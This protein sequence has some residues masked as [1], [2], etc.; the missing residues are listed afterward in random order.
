[1]QSFFRH[2]DVV[3]TSSWFFFCSV[4]FVRSSVRPSI[5]LRPHIS[6]FASFE[7]HLFFSFTLNHTIN[8]ILNKTSFSSSSLRRIINGH[9]YRRELMGDIGVLASWSDRDGRCSRKRSVGNIGLRLFV[10]AKGQLLRPLKC[11]GGTKDESMIKIMSAHKRETQ[12]R[13]KIC[14][15]ALC[16]SLFFSLSE[17][18]RWGRIKRSETGS[19][20]DFSIHLRDATPVVRQIKIIV[21]TRSRIK[22]ERIRRGWL[23]EPRVFLNYIIPRLL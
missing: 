22:R 13:L 11:D 8:P 18:E 4:S 19:I 23:F 20:T 12:A 5:R 7:I 21:A 2:F 6:S 16:L 3:L 15:G 14:L 10:A 1:M 17:C 9:L